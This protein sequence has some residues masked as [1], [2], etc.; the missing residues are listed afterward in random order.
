MHARRTA[1]SSVGS[2]G[3]SSLI[4]ESMPETA[5][6]GRV[7]WPQTQLTICE[8]ASSCSASL[9]DSRCQTYSP[10]QSPPLA[11]SASEKRNVTCLANVSLLAR[12][13][14]VALTLVHVG[15]PA[16]SASSDRRPSKR[17][18][19]EPRRLTSSSP[20]REKAR[21]DAPAPRRSY[22]ARGPQLS[23]S[24]RGQKACVGVASAGAPGAS[25]RTSYSR[26][27]GSSQPMANA[28]LASGAKASVVQPPIADRSTRASPPA[29]GGSRRS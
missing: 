28:P 26:T 3:L 20:E 12:P 19:S 16:T 10:P 2:P 25:L 29:R 15:T 21:P 7:G 6:S 11:T 17:K 8:S 5:T 24:S 1:S 9:P 23:T 18:M 27:I 4:S 13:R 22:E 14:Y